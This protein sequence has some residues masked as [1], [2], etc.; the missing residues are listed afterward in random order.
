MCVAGGGGGV[1]LSSLAVTHTLFAHT[2]TQNSPIIDFYPSDFKVDLNGKR[3]MW[4]G[5]ALL[6]FVDETRLL[7]ALKQHYHTLTHDEGTVYMC[8]CLGKVHM[9]VHSLYICYILLVL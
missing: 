4:Q 7:R 9:C 5:V 2:H 8:T 1:C 3:Y 6:P